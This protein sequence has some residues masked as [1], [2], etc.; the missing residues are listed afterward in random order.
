MKC[1]EIYEGTSMS[2]PNCAGCIALILS[3]LKQNKIEF[4][5][6]GIKRALENTSRKIDDEI[7]ASGAG[8]VQ[9]EPA[10]DYLV[11]YQKNIIQN[12]NFDFEINLNSKKF[13]GIY[14]TDEND[15]T[16]SKEYLVKVIP[17][18]FEGDNLKKSQD[19]SYKSKY[20][21]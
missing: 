6:Y 12:I 2:S 1:I 21:V 20:L 19:E 10:Y 14:L 16:N 3:G 4:N 13:R 17:M 8:L 15:V 7:L 18:F 5:P 9:V 11:E